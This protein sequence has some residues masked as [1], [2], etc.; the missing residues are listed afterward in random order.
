V[1]SEAFQMDAATISALRQPMIR[2]HL[3]ISRTSQKAISRIN[4]IVDIRAF[5]RLN[6]QM[7]LGNSDLEFC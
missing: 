4:R 2:Q 3:V 7:M 6:G 1:R 5:V